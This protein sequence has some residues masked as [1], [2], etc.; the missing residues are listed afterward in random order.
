[1]LTQFS[2]VWIIILET[3]WSHLIGTRLT[4]GMKRQLNCPSRHSVK[5]KII[6]S[7]LL[8]TYQLFRSS[9]T[10]MRYGFTN[11]FRKLTL[12]KTLQLGVFKTAIKIPNLS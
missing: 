3:L 11:N 12:L 8:S 6:E 2:L 1:M 4:S 10:E 9:S 5:T 7:G